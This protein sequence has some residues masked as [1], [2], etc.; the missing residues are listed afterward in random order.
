MP[1][2][3]GQ[4][5]QIR[6]TNV[7]ASF[8][9]RPSRKFS[10]PR[11]R[12]PWAL[13]LMIVAPVS[14]VGRDLD[15]KVTFDAGYRVDF[16]CSSRSISHLLLPPFEFSSAPRTVRSCQDSPSRCTPCRGGQH[17]CSGRRSW[18]CRWGQG[19]PA[20]RRSPS[21]PGW[22]AA[23]CS[24]RGDR[25]ATWRPGPCNRSS[26]GNRGRRAGG[27]DALDVVAV[28]RAVRAVDRV[29]VDGLDATSRIHAAADIDADTQRVVRVG[30][31]LL[32]HAERAH[33]ADRCAQD[34]GDVDEEADNRKNEPPGVRRATGNVD[35][36][37][38]HVGVRVQRRGSRTMP[39]AS[40]C[41]LP[42]SK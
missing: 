4:T 32:E 40:V 33:G 10:K 35:D 20:R 39:S 16:V 12:L 11:H 1:W 19:W 25:K 22:S 3:T 18:S 30:G 13:A 17:E 14:A 27:V 21:R 7:I 24:S 2:G 15:A 29:A 37:A 5:P 31:D 23:G 9:A 34:A 42:V 26:A 36:L 38:G 28:P 8:A 6:C 41:D